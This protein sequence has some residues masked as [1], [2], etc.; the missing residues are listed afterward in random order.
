MEKGAERPQR[1]PDV[2]FAGQMQDSSFTTPQWLIQRGDRYLQVS[3]LLYRVAEAAD[4]THSY[5]DIAVLVGAA[6][7]RQVSGDDVRVLVQ[8][9]LAPAG[10][11]AASGP[12]V[13]AAF[14]RRTQD[15]SPLR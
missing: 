2:Q 13:D 5:D 3:E 6:T 10:I 7:R 1:A 12:A 4:G 15:P 8:E 14:T 9:R 11:V